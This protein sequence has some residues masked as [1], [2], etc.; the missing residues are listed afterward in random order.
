[1][2]IRDLNALLI[3]NAYSVSSQSEIIDDLLEC[4]YLS[5]LN[6]NAFFYQWRIHSNDA[7][8]QTVVTHREQRI[9]LIFIMNNRNFVTYVQRQMN[10]L[11][12]EFRKFVKIYIDDI[13][14]KSKTFQKHLNHLKILFRIFLKKEIIINSFK[15][16]LEYQS[17]ILL[18]QRVNALK[19]ITAEE[20]LKAISFFRFSENLI[21][22]ERY[23]D[24]VDYLRDKIYFFVDVFKSFQKLKI[25]LLKNF[26]KKNRRKKFINRTKI[27][28]I[29][30]KMTS[31]LLLQ[32]N[33]TKTILLI[34]FD[35]NK[36]FWIDLDEFKEFDFE[37]I[38]FHVIKKFSKETW[39]IKN[40]IQ[41]IMF[42]SRLL[43]FAKKNYWFI[44]LKTVEL[45]WVI[46]KVKHLIQSFE[47][48]I[49]IQT[50]HATIMNICK[51]TLIISTN[52][53]MRMNLRLV[54]T[55]QFLSQFSN[56]KIRHKSKKYHLISDAFF[57]LQRLNKKD[58]SNDHAEL[59]E[60][61]VDHN[62]IHAYNTILMKLN[63]EFRARIMKKY[64]KNES[65]RKIIQII[66]QNETLSENVAELSFVR[67]SATVL[68]ESDFYMTSNI[69]SKSTKQIS[70]SNEI[71]KNSRSS[72][73]IL[74]FNENSKESVSSEHDDKDL[75]YHVNKSTEMKRL[76]IS[77]DCVSN[78]L[79]IVHEWEQ[80]H[81]EFEITFEI[82]LRA[83]YI[84]D[85]I[86][87]LRFY[88][89]NCSQCLQI[90]IRRH[91]SWKNLQFIHSF[92]I[93][94]HT[95]TM[96]FV[97]ELLKI[98][99]EINCVLSMTNKFTKR[100]MLIS[101]K[102]TYTTENWA[103]Q[104]LKESQRRDWDISKVII[105]NR[106][107][108]FL[109]DLWCTLFIRLRIFMLYFTA[110]H[111]QTNKTSERTNQ[112]LKITLR[113]YIQK[114]F[115][116]T[117]WISA[118]WKFQSIFNN[119]RSIVTE[120]ISNELLY[121]I[122]SNLSLNI[123]FTNKIFNH[124]HLRKEAKN[125]INW[126]QMQN[127]AHYNRRHTSLF[128]KI[129]KW[130]LLRFHHEYFISRS[131]NMTKNIFTQYIESFKIIQRI[132]RLIYR[133]NISSDWKIH[134]V[135]FVTQLK[136]ASNSANDSYHRSR[137]THSSSMTNTQNEYEIERIL[138]KRTVKRDQEYFTKFLVRWQDY[139]FEY[140]RWYNV[141]N[142]QNAK[143]LISDY[144][145]K[146]ER[147][148]SSN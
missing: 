39:S 95:I 109:S 90:Q 91:K 88:I 92:S 99:E 68:R 121:E 33:F 81:S 66:N 75:I 117:L 130:I 38:V 129:D 114:M 137:S 87:T 120:K 86:K 46:K 85:L 70:S 124:D 89:R 44:E 24:L 26:F 58:L 111:S 145:K 93:S 122:T 4:K 83:W 140:D 72:K 82:I 80:N 64:S 21:A 27:I 2:N 127:K 131:K 13:I 63:S 134:F 104:L 47:K 139:E 23:L 35:K 135:F 17:V 123:S 119:T 125:V 126:A 8:K 29:D 147:F 144:E 20:K 43:I 59:N 146:L 11:L 10:I 48:S 32:K 14:C 73:S 6:V 77:S 133:L 115:N 51:Q 106:D 69:N 5:I 30:K 97:L 136:F 101:E 96:N 31:F 67:E 78:I 98:K 50:N 110:Y 116:S 9:F 107:R 57:R 60:L 16:F 71:Q 61:F 76:C 142:L 45:I 52:F 1:V 3:S 113:Y 102:F 15:T 62:V 94:F 148:N 118:L 112:T 128:L 41:L 22:L 103:V 54:R 36:W 79:I 138:N 56:L 12:N 34:H 40:D 53:V 141:K 25:N 132:E 7:Y 55:S 19:L 84:R 105:S 49:I 65:W 18:K 100:I 28:F 42:L 108:K 74:R 143:N 37:V